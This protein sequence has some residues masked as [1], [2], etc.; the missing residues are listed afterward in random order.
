MS[1]SW[2][3]LR[4]GWTFGAG[5]LTLKK[6]VQIAR[7]KPRRFPVDAPLG[8]ESEPRQAEAVTRSNRDL[9][10]FV[11]MIA[12]YGQACIEIALSNDCNA[13]EGWRQRA[14]EARM[15]LTRAIEEVLTQAG[16]NQVD[17]DPVSAEADQIT[18][19]EG[20]QS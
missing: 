19:P 15:K 1:S 14:V 18:F 16:S 5:G 11:E 4:G 17:E 7:R 3:D 6:D 10:E 20:R 12:D 8:H 13:H 9:S 2:A